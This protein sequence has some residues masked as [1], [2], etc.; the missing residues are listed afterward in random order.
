MTR[1]APLFPLLVACLVCGSASGQDKFVTINIE[2]QSPEFKLEPTVV[3]PSGEF[4]VFQDAGSNKY[5]YSFKLLESDWFN[6]ADINITWKNAYL[7][8]DFSQFDFVQRAELRLRYD[9][10]KDYTMPVFFS[11]DRTE[12]EIDRLDAITDKLQQWQPFFRAWQIADFYSKT[13]PLHRLARRSATRFLFAADVLAERDM[14]PPQ[15]IVIMSED[16]VRF[17]QNS[18]V[19]TPAL[20]KRIDTANSAFWE[21]L[22]SLD[23]IAQ[24]GDCAIARSLLAFLQRE[25]RD[26]PELFR[27]RYPKEPDALEQ[28]KSIVDAKC[29]S[30]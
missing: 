15:F 17:A 29:P 21:D 8:A 22:P 28:K 23:K 20:Q 5:S 16:A 4:G 18:K 9:F 19:I 30:T 14:P 7:N 3:L 2:N 24:R 13:S 6:T 1:I 25:K 26:R 12:K 27:L 10:P 11:N